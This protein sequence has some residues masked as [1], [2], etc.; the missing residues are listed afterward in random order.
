MSE[1]E[2]DGVAVGTNE[3]DE[4]GNSDGAGAGAA[5][6]DADG[7]DGQGNSD[8]VDSDDDGKSDESPDGDADAPAAVNEE[9]TP[10]EF[11]AVRDRLVLTLLAAW[12]DMKDRVWTSTRQGM[13]VV[14]FGEGIPLSGVGL[15]ADRPGFGA[16]P[17]RDDG[18]PNPLWHWRQKY[19][20]KMGNVFAAYGTPD[21]GFVMSKQDA[22]E[23]VRMFQDLERV[24]VNEIVHYMAEFDPS[25]RGGLTFKPALVDFIR[26]ATPVHQNR[27]KIV[28][29]LQRVENGA[30]DG[31]KKDTTKK[32]KKKK[33]TKEEAQLQ[34]DGLV[35]DLRRI[36]GELLS[37]V[38][39]GTQGEGTPM[40]KAEIQ[41]GIATKIQTKLK[42]GPQQERKLETFEGVCALSQDAALKFILAVRA[43]LGASVQEPST[44]PLKKMLFCHPYIDTS[45]TEEGCTDEKCVARKEG[46]IRPAY[47]NCPETQRPVRMGTVLD[48][49]NSYYV[50]E[51]KPITDWDLPREW[52]GAE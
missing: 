48:Q 1:A 24:L 39:A 16:K 46:G 32:K 38:R 23:R 10:E 7:S 44:D 35:A 14:I 31:Q 30:Q 29:A 26:A 2:D 9:L 15:G 13:S 21:N 43:T 33:L 17:E 49:L 28:R 22:D 45:C 37:L 41:Q 5:D 36:A 20:A 34:L 19:P 11:A 51:D 25:S 18:T 47:G 3:Q 50:E 4:H 8:V 6:D 42:V 52:T 27:A 12:A 40:S